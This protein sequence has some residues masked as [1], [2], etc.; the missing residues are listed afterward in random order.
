MMITVFT[1]HSTDCP[2]NGDRDWKR[3]NCRKWLYVEG[4]RKPISAKTRSWE[5]AQKK[6]RELEES[7]AKGD[8]SEAAFSVKP[9]TTREAVS[10]FLEN[11]AQEGHSKA[12]NRMLRRD[13]MDFANWCS[14]NLVTP[15]NINTLALEEYRKTWQ[16]ALGTRARRQE[17]LSHFSNYCVNHD[18]MRQNFVAKMSKIKVAEL[19]TLPLTR[20]EFERTIESAQQYNPKS[21]DAGWRRQRALAMLL[22]LRWSGLRISDAGKLERS[23]L[24]DDGKLFLYTQKTGQPVYVPLPPGVAKLLRDLPNLENP[25]YFFWNGTSNAETP[26]KAWWKTLKK[27]FKAAG[28]N[29]HPHMLRDTFAVEML[30]AGVSLEEVSVLLGHSNTKVTEK[31]YKPWVRA[32]QEQ[33]E[34]SVLKAW[35]T[36]PSMANPLAAVESSAIVN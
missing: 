2:R 1:R 8:Q 34:R 19:P 15:A 7:L 18:W 6:A 17:R 32:R 4:S 12:W 30:S 21:P 33:L 11:K 13:L 5:A 27:I 29:A 20:E 9:E 24:T 26:G 28:V 25:H 14:T 31:H 36:D 35:A 23:K 10:K 3:C 22:L 16:G